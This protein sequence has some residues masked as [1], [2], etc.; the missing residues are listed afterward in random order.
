MSRM[1]AGLRNP[2]NRR[3]A[4]TLVSGGMIALALLA[5]YGLGSLGA[6]SLL[7]AAAALVAGGDIAVRAWHALRARSF[8]IELLVTI[9]A[10]GALAIGEYWEAAAVTF[11]FMLGAWLEAR[12]M[13]QT[14]GALRALLD[15]APSV[16]TV[17]RDDQPVDMA[18]HEVRVGEMVLVRPGQKIPVDG[19]VSEGAAAVDESAI[20]GE[21]IPV[22]KSAGSRV[23]SGTIAHNGMLQVRAL[24]VGAD[25]TLARIVRRV[26]EA[27]EE[28]APTQRLIE[29]FAQWYTPGVV[30]LAGFAFLFT[31]DVRLA[32]T[33]L[34]VACPG[35]LV[36]ST[37][38]SVVAGIG[39][40]AREGILIK[41]G[42]HLENAGRIT[43]LAVDK[44]GTLTEG[45]PKLVDVAAFAPA[46]A[47]HADRMVL[48]S[49]PGSGSAAT[50]PDRWT[51][52]APWTDASTP[53]G[54][55]RRVR[56]P[57]PRTA[58]P[59]STM[60]SPPS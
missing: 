34:V 30:L 49:T 5:R 27:Q 28:R 43:T 55:G 51:P 1:I 40:A 58:C 25:T 37:P 38:V 54:T 18:P 15:A 22:E 36:I 60:G 14:R 48:C 4:L 20:T 52:S 35:A 56:P 41:G 26:E 59:N 45:R 57:P 13:R 11:L 50:A 7:M 2:T 6:W 24:G 53:V 3:L 29:R 33:L 8:S 19:E 23:F 17:L 42:Q 39:R 47:G 16:A 12:T 44:T 46:H 21:P 9:A 10:A 32:L 31:G